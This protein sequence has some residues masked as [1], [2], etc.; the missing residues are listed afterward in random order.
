MAVIVAGSIAV[1]HL[2]NFPGRFAD[3]LVSDKLSNVSL[4][5]L[6]EDL[7]IRR[8]GVGANICFG[9]G[10]LGLQ[11]TLIAAAGSDFAD[12]R[13]HLQRHGVR[14]DWV[15]IDEHEHTAR[16]IC[17][18][19]RDQNQ[20]AVFYPGAM[21]Q[22]RFTTL[23]PA[24]QALSGPEHGEPLVVISPDDPDAMLSH[25]RECR[26]KGYRFVAD[27]SQQ[28][29][30]MNGT[31]IRELITGAHLVFTNDYEAALL[32]QKTGWS[33]T[34]VLG[35]VGTWV[36]TTGAQGVT[37]LQKDQQPQQVPAVQAGTIVDP[38]GVGDGFR[39]GFLAGLQWS[40]PLLQCAQLGALMGTVVLESLG[41]QAYHLDVA[42]WLSRLS[43]QYG[44]QAAQVL[45]EHLGAISV[46]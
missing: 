3:S 44:P 20:I 36:R 11:P 40:V 12:Y 21:R 7:T 19:D 9:L 37:I 2:M 18:T 4:S 8:G 27:P 24:V 39:A 29:A 32:E 30:R 31:Q 38:T 33:P 1:D 17:T 23:E 16:F 26:R 28:L 42:L 14:C 46:R 10:L 13:L 43:A 25:T 6:V 41:P 15:V 45:Q 5:F 34:E 35:Q 22:A